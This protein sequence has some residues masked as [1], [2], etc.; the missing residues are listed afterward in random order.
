MHALFLEPFHPFSY[1][2]LQKLK[3]FNVAQYAYHFFKVIEAMSA[4]SLIHPLGCLPRFGILREWLLI[5]KLSFIK[6]YAPA[7]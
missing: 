6:S 7:P 1:H 3:C 4:A 2:L 5:N